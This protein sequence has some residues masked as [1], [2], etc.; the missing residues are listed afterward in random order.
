ME[1]ESVLRQDLID[2]FVSVAHGDFERV[3]SLLNK[4]PGLVRERASWNETGIEAAA[5]T[6]Q[7]EIVE[8]LLKA[9]APLDICTAAVLGQQEEVEAFLNTDPELVNAIGAHGIPLLYFPVIMG[10]K[11]I[12]QVVLEHGAN[13]NAGQGGNTALHGAVLFNQ[14]E[15]VSWLLD[16]GAIPDP[17]DYSGKTP[18]DLA[19]EKGFDE[20]STLLRSR[21]DQ[22]QSD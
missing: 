9:G 12:T 20:I 14:A 8:Y 19:V 15:M 3:K 4:Y 18:L 2:E 1:V 6:G 10:H 7:V 16:Q 13:V 22:A 17:L 5:Q 21:M 11:E